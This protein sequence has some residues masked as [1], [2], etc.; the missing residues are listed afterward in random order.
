MKITLERL[1]AIKARLEAVP[2]GPLEECMN[3]GTSRVLCEP[4]QPDGTAKQILHVVGLDEAITRARS[5][6]YATAHEDLRD[7]V[8]AA[9]Y[10]M[11]TC[12]CCAGPACALHGSDER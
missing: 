5:V 8:E 1:H 9:I 2:R 10:R 3:F 11:T 12:T 4:V 7:L 6:F